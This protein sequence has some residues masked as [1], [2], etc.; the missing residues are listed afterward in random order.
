M[1]RLQPF[2]VSW[3]LYDFYC[4]RSSQQKAGHC[5]NL[6]FGNQRGRMADTLELDQPRARAALRH[7]MRRLGGQQIRLRT[8]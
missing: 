1:Y 7:G 4:P 8:A 6:V 3:G 2:Y 5:I